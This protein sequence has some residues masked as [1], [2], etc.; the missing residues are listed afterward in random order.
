[1][2][3]AEASTRRKNI[4]AVGSTSSTATLMKRYDEPQTAATMARRDT[5]P[6]A[7]FG[8]YLRVFVQPRSV[9]PG[10]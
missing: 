4:I 1:M 5:Y 6:R 7:M 8:G 10:R 2:S 3:T 9:L